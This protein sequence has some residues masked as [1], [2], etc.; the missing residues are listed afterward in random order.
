MNIPILSKLFSKKKEP[1]AQIDSL[2]I[3]QLKKVANKNSF[4]LFENTPV[5]YHSTK[6]DIPLA[7][8]LPQ[9][10][11]VLFE[12]KEWHFE[13]LK[14][15]VASKTSHAKSAPNTLSFE[16]RSDF[17]REKFLDLSQYEDIDIFNFVLMEHLSE[18]EF[19]RLD[20]SFHQYLPKERILF[21]DS[22]DAN[23]EKKF[24][25]LEPRRTDYTRNNTLPYI[26]SQYMILKKETPFFATKS[27]REF[28][29]SKEEATQCISLYAPRLSGK[30]TI[31]LQKA[32]LAHLL[33]PQH[34]VAVIAPTLLHVELLRHLLLNIIE[35]SA[36]VIDMNA[37]EIL[38]GD[39]LI[40]RHSHA[41]GK[42][43]L[44]SKIERFHFN[45]DFHFA[46]TLYID[47]SDL[48]EE[49]FVSYLLKL[50]KKR[51]LLLVN[52]KQVSPTHTLEQSYHQESSFEVT[53]SCFTT[54]L[55]TLHK[56]NPPNTADVLIFTDSTDKE[57]MAEDIYG[58]TGREVEIFNMQ[59]PLHE[60]QT[61]AILL[62]EYTIYNPLQCDYA[63][64]LDPCCS[65]IET[66]SY[67]NFA[68]HKK[69]FFLS[70][71]E[72]DTIS[73]LEKELE[74][75]GKSDEKSSQK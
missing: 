64:F 52:P 18:E 13:E 30:S 74:E 34:K 9:K 37:V 57:A 33:H 24:S 25:S 44:S 39:E 46:D 56:L 75:K 15:V 50:Q 23:I 7:V 35:R 59:I 16:N 4:D 8:F 70:E 1:L 27:Q 63:F 54:L 11:L 31:L 66:L 42:K 65:D 38:C 2:L 71:Q 6:M 62:C 22:T 47:D 20:E 10:G 68:S 73:K 36:L 17:I 28:I 43:T 69:S 55:K 21:S 48:M 53:S 19:D 5:F 58:F 49:K 32:L 61:D 72:C 45:K 14:D 60:Q 26:F 67:L 29:D 12:Y 51:T 3:Q 40:R 41:L